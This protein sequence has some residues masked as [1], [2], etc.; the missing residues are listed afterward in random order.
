MD[1]PG[2]TDCATTE[3]NNSTGHWPPGLPPLSLRSPRPLSLV[4]EAH[5]ELATHLVLPVLRDRGGRGGGRAAPGEP[6][7][8]QE[9]QVTVS[10]N[11]SKQ[12]F[13]GTA[14]CETLLRDVWDSISIYWGPPTAAHRKCN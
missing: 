4:L 5:E 3:A 6:R 11:G 9:W 7:S 12:G 10:Q 8:P 13:G 1:Q 14:C 2:Q